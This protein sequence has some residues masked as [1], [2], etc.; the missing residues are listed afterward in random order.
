MTP[1][2]SLQNVLAVSSLEQSGIN[3]TFGRWICV[4]VPFCVL[5]TLIAWMLCEIKTPTYLPTYLPTYCLVPASLTPL[6]SNPRHEPHGRED[7]AGDRVRARPSNEQE[8]HRHHRT[9]ATHYRPLRLLLLLEERLRR[10]R[11]PLPLLCCDHVRHW[12]ALGGGLQLV[13]VA[14]SLPR[15]RRQRTRKGTVLYSSSFISPLDSF[16][17]PRRWNHRACCITS[18]TA[19]LEDCL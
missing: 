17:L 4:S 10:H 18:L 6:R 13:V 9:L 7:R 3:V 11:H 16:L 19:S 8:R 12:H 5:S 1:I 15:R 14:H 2:S